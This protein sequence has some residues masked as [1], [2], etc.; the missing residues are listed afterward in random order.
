MERVKQMRMLTD[1]VS[2][3]FKMAKRIISKEQRGKRLYRGV[4][5]RSCLLALCKDLSW[6][7]RVLTIG[8]FWLH[9]SLIILYNCWRH[10]NEFHILLSIHTQLKTPS[11]S[12]TISTGHVL[13]G[14]V[15]KIPNQIC[16]YPRQILFY[17]LP[18][19]MNGNSGFQGTQPETLGGPPLVITI[20]LTPRTLCQLYLP[21]TFRNSEFSHSLS[22]FASLHHS[23]SGL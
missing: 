11:T 9:G 16:D 15:A 6:F 5:E 4:L 8:S 3:H 13:E 10:A 14:Q 18:I 17:N 12:S 22:R 23:L 2:S 20:D 7:I 1:G 19:F 21:A